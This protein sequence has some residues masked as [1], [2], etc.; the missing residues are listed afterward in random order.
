[1]IGSEE[2][3]ILE[4]DAVSG[5]F[6]TNNKVTEY[7]D[8]LYAP[9]TAEL[10]SLREKA[11]A[12]GIPVILRDTESFLNVMVR[13][14]GA[15]RVLEIGTAVGYS[16]CCF[17]EMCGEGCEIVTLERDP[18][19]AARAAVNISSLG[20]SDRI[21]ILEGEALEKLGELEGYFDLVFIDA[22]KS[23]YR[24]FWDGAA[25]RCRPGSVIICDNVLMR[26][27][28]ASEE[29]DSSARRHRT[30]IRRMRSFL[31]YITNTDH[32]ETSVLAAGDGI[33]VSYIKAGDGNGK[34]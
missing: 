10:G 7:L 15:K 11:E 34:D 24:A 2:R 17:A 23:H 1:M 16:A 12:E 22:G 5:R 28:V 32:A 8:G 30:S 13:I 31:E 20:Y 4:A 3:I 21:K 18:E 14:T 25:A 26:G 27:S 29:Y 6:I 33:S 19:M 9:I